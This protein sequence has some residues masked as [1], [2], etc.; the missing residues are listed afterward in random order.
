MQTAPKKHTT[1]KRLVRSWQLW[2]LILPALI[3]VA[4]FHYAPM[5]GLLIAFKNYKPK[6]GILL[7]PW[8]GLKYFQ[9]F[10]RTDIAFK[11]IL[12]TLRLSLSTL[13][14][15]F[16]IPIILALMLN[17]IKSVRTKRFV[18]TATYLPYFIS[19]V[20]VVGVMSVILNPTTGFVNRFLTDIGVGSRMFMARPEYFVPVYVLSGIW[21]T[22]GFN[23][24]IYI[25]AL[26]TISPDL[27]EAAMI[28]GASRFKQVLYIEIPALLPT[29]VIM[30][31][32][33]TG[34]MLTIGYEKVYLMQTGMNLSVS[35]VVSTYVYKVGIQSAQ[36]SFASAV[37]MFNSVANLLILLLTN[38]LAG[39]L[40]NVSLF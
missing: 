25:S 29:I 33:A 10:F 5:Y 31:V 8:A 11:S 30:L 40:S 3:W 26:T 32:L 1:L 9:Q 15:S 22:A 38:W 18:Q 37:G 28:D 2:V 27:Y 39:R 14:F 6:L 23:A 24:I 21:Q 13:V 4:V 16:P 7:S 12:N 17:Q 34:N 35:E 36:F 19:S 20:V